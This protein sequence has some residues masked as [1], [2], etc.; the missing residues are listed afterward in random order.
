MLRLILKDGNSSNCK[1]KLDDF[2]N[3]C[4]DFPSGPVVKYNRGSDSKVLH[5]MLLFT[6]I[7]HPFLLWK[8]STRTKYNHHLLNAFYSVGM[9][10]SISNKY[11]I[12]N[13]IVF[14]IR[15]S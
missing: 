4:R 12:G 7:S 10:L 9:E 1:K 8:L 5:I 11:D 2:N 15:R 6:L 13:N 3:A 14:Y